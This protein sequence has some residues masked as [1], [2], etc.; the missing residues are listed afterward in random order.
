[1]TINSFL[2]VNKLLTDRYSKFRTTI[3]NPFLSINNLLTDRYIKYSEINHLLN[4][5]EGEYEQ[6][7]RNGEGIGTLINNSTTVFNNNPLFL[8]F[9]YY[10]ELFNEFN[11]Y[12]ALLK[13]KNRSTN[14]EHIDTEVNNPLL[15]CEEQIKSMN[16]KIFT[17]IVKINT[18]T[19][20]AIIDEQLNARKARK[21]RNEKA[22]EKQ[23]KVPSQDQEE[24]IVREFI[25]EDN[26]NSYSVENLEPVKPGIE[27][28]DIENMDNNYYIISAVKD[29]DCFISAI[30]DYGVYT[31]SL[32]QIY[33]KIMA[34]DKYIQSKP[35]YKYEE[36]KKSALEKLKIA[37]GS[38]YQKQHQ[39]DK[40]DID[41]FNIVNSYEL[42]ISIFYNDHNVKKIYNGIDYYRYGNTFTLNNYDNNTLYEKLRLSFVISMKYIIYIYVKTIGKKI[43]EK[44]IKDS[45]IGLGDVGEWILKEQYPELDNFLEELEIKIANGVIGTKFSNF[46]VESVMDFHID[47]Y[48]S[49]PT[50]VWTDAALISTFQQLLIRKVKGCNYR[51]DINTRQ[52]GIYRFKVNNTNRILKDK[53]EKIYLHL[54]LKERHYFSL[55]PIS[56]NSNLGKYFLNKLNNIQSQSISYEIY[57]ERLNEEAIR[58]MMSEIDGGKRIQPKSLQK[59]ERVTNDPKKPS[60]KK[61]SPKKPSPKKP[62]KSKQKS[63]LT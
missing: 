5:R 62:C 30:F 39:K 38:K 60:P 40:K 52:K 1:M 59:S 12:E 53:T 33:S 28:I 50:S 22:L 63:R 10:C 23:V 36:L 43:F 45:I 32:P 34:M 56:E 6:F 4:I 31:E 49:K 9:T 35:I 54:L 25:E 57:E 18:K 24:K 2:S 47:N 7:K 51:I 13:Q 16:E 21:A 8:L 61:P 48:L 26:D 15:D 11:R 55:L 58:R 3:T 44:Y 27:D 29:G 20:Q 19:D 14:K 17:E 41:S 37:Y 46:D 42:F